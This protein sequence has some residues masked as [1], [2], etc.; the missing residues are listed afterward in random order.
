MLKAPP[1]IS[2][3]IHLSVIK[4]RPDWGPLISSKIC[5]Y[6]FFFSVL[7]WSNF[8][9]LFYVGSP[10][11]LSLFDHLKNTGPRCPA[12]RPQCY[13]PWIFQ[14]R[15]DNDIMILIN[16]VPRISEVVLLASALKTFGKAKP[17]HINFPFA[18]L[19]KCI[20]SLVVI[21]DQLLWEKLEETLK[22]R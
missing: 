2:L 22:L 19:W 21:T 4:K 10:N 15:S 17:A 16:V 7:Y 14:F 6:F 3:V 8:V 1:L 18:L 12:V 5:S 9:E 13:K 11:G 20:Y